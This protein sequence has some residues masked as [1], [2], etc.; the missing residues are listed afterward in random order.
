MLKAKQ[1]KA[2][3]AKPFPLIDVASF[4]PAWAE[5]VG[6]HGNP[7]T[8]AADCDHQCEEQGEQRGKKKRLDLARWIAA[9][10]CYALAASA[11]DVSPFSCASRLLVWLFPCLQVWQ[12][13]ATMA[14]MRVCLEVATNAAAEDKRYA[15]AVIYDEECR[16]EW[17]RRASRGALQSP[18]HVFVV[19]PQAVCLGQATSPSILMWS[20]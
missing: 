2:G 10:Q 19:A 4:L 3:V 15:L 14:H 12:Y 6:L 13:T 9:Y 16:K 17:H 5:E 7:N 20:V 1:A 11:A 8:E 18:S